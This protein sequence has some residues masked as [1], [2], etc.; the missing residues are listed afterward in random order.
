MLSTLPDWAEFLS[1]GSAV[2]TSQ[3]GVPVPLVATSPTV[4]GTT[5]E[6]VISGGVS[7]KI[8]KIENTVTFGS[9]LSASRSFQLVIEAQ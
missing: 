9:G 1:E 4:S 8:Y 3:W 7:G 2:E 5:T 6:I